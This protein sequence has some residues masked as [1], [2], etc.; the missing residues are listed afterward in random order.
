MWRIDDP[1]GDEAQKVK[2][3]VVRWTR[4]TGLDIGCGPYKVWPHLIGVD[5]MHHAREFG[6]KMKPDIVSEAHNLRVFSDNSMDFVFSSH[7]LEHI[8]DTARALSEWWRVIKPGGY[9][10]LYL[11]N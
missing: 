6:W 9:L 3:D 8:E 2:Y 11:P 5:N 4:G 10:I 7:T 1:Q